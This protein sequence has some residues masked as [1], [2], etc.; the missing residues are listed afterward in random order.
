MEL[1]LVGGVCI[2]TEVSDGLERSDVLEALSDVVVV[3]LFW[4]R[5]GA[6]AWPLADDDAESLLC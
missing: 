3:D 1:M 6:D 5:I 4:A 2:E